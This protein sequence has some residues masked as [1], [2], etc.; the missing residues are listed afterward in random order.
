MV[1]AVVENIKT[2]S[3]ISFTRQVESGVKYFAQLS[4]SGKQVDPSSDG[5][6]EAIKSEAPVIRDPDDFLDWKSSHI[7]IRF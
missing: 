4:I 7:F 3:S 6:V 5:T 1:N 2:Q